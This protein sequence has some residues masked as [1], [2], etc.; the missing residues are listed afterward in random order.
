MKSLLIVAIAIVCIVAA[1][2]LVVCKIAWEITKNVEREFLESRK[3]PSD[4]ADTKK[5]K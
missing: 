2:F 3:K 1:G 4:L 5:E